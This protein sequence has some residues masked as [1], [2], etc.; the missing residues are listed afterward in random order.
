[1]L[2]LLFKE[3]KY[4]LRSMFTL[5]LLV[6]SGLLT[7]S[8]GVEY[9]SRSGITAE[10]AQLG[11]RTAAQEW[12]HRTSLSAVGFPL[13]AAT[14]IV[15]LYGTRDRRN[16]FASLVYTRPV[17]TPRL[18]ASKVAG[19]VSGILLLF[20][21]GVVAGVLTTGI[22]TGLWPEPGLFVQSLLFNLLPGLVAWTVLVLTVT[23]VLPD[24][25]SSIFPLVVLWLLLTNI[26]ASS[27]FWFYRSIDQPLTPLRNLG[28]WM[29]IVYSAAVTAASYL[30]LLWAVDRRR[31]GCAWSLGRRH[32]RRNFR[33]AP[34]PLMGRL[35]LAVRITAGTK[36]YIALLGVTGLALL[37][38]SPFGMLRG[39]PMYVKEY[40]SLAF[41]ELL[42]PLLGL[43]IA[44]DLLP[45]V[46]AQSMEEIIKQRPGGEGQLLQQKLIGLGAYL[47]VNCLLYSLWL[48]V[49][50]PSISFL[51]AL[52]VLFPSV[53][54][55]SSL[56]VALVVVCKSVF[57]AY[58][59]SLVYWWVSYS[60]QE[61]F[62]WFLSPVYHLA[63]YSFKLQKD[64]LWANKLIVLMVGIGFLAYSLGKTLG[65]PVR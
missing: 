49:F 26:P 63:E 65:R 23:A 29:R 35:G 39:Q 18:V 40:Y 17:E 28:V 31:T 32:R 46:G 64:L 43:L 24:L 56:A 10:A 52:G 45:P 44:Y 58:V 30:L 16:N 47:A 12:A 33:V 11:I 15:W 13:L 9:A 38:A 25:K 36:L 6:L 2:A 19:L 7:H 41:S 21:G 37:L 51:Q 50:V 5:V 3:L 48:Q 60:L 57:V 27:M 61:T 8:A 22:A 1:M 42:F 53:L 34:S 59:I 4:N 62:P 55:L 20:L 14:A 54:F